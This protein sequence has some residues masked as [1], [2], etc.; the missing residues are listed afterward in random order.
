MSD[1]IEAAILAA[2]QQRGAGRSLCPSE[3]ARA[4]A[5][6]AWRPLMP[7]IR[8]AAG[9]LA[10]TGALRVTQRGRPVDIETARGPV[11]LSLG[12]ASRDPTS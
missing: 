11:R 1:P 3:V 10:A 8:T 4:L 9:R 7:A 6:E 5:P 12:P 2:V